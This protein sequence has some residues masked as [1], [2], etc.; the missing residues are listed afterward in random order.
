MCLGWVGKL[1]NVAMEK[2]INVERFGNN[3]VDDSTKPKVRE[4]ECVLQQIQRNTVYGAARPKY[5]PK[6][7]QVMDFRKVKL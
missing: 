7:V 1:G 5:Q 6:V 4:L 2:T 3:P